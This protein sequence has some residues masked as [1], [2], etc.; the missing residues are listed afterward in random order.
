MLKVW[1]PL[2]KDLRNIGTSD[3]E[4]SVISPNTTLNSNGFFGSC[5]SNNSNTAGG[6][7][8]DKKINL[9]QTQSMF[10]WIKLN[11]ICSSSSLQ[12]VLG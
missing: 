9:G 12:A 3:L 8:S 10:C 7:V 2:N 6:I 1:L 5:Y 11:S 4:F